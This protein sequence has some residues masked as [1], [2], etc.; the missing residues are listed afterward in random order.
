MLWWFKPN[1]SITQ[2]EYRRNY[3]N[4]VDRKAKLTVILHYSNNNPKCLCCNETDITKLTID[5][6]NGGGKTHRKKLRI[7][8]GSPFYKWLIRQG[9]PKGYQILCLYCNNSKFTGKK[10]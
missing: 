1:P 9:L 3:N 4:K 7:N 5:H 6:I 2:L 10:C 8:G